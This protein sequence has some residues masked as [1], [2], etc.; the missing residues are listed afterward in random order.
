MCEECDNLKSQLAQI[1]LQLEIVEERLEKL[2]N[3]SDKKRKSENISALK[4]QQFK[5]DFEKL[6]PHEYNN[7]MTNYE[8]VLWG[9]Y[10]SKDTDRP[11]KI[12][13]WKEFAQR[14]K[15]INSLIEYFSNIAKERKLED[16]EN[17]ARRRLKLYI[18]YCIMVVKDKDGRT[19]SF[20]QY[21]SDWYVNNY[22]DKIAKWQ[23]IKSLPDESLD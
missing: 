7:P 16:H 12:D 9:S 4:L 21:T 20:Y 19:P 18:E 15:K 5:E 3:N 1:N 22:I 2:E 17:W 8:L 23:Q 6:R 14:T 10:V 13:T 11:D